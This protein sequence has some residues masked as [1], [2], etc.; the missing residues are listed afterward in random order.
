ME[1]NSSTHLEIRRKLE[2]TNSLYILAMSWIFRK[3]PP[4]VLIVVVAFLLVLGIATPDLTLREQLFSFV[5]VCFWAWV[6]LTILWSY[7]DIENDSLN[8]C[9]AKTIAFVLFVFVYRSSALSFLLYH[10][11]HFS[12]SVQHRL[13]VPVDSVLQV[14]F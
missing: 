11:H 8:A 6:F 13:E 2:K 12:K 10:Q 7:T 3:N 4:I 1:L 5:R 14:T 9:I